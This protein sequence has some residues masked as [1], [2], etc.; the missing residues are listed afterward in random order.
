MN[1][2]WENDA[3]LYR[4]A[5]D[6]RSM[7]N[8]KLYNLNVV[9]SGKRAIRYFDNIYSSLT[10]KVSWQPKYTTIKDFIESHSSC[11]P[12]DELTLIYILY[13]CYSEVYYKYNPIGE[14]ETKESFDS[15]Y[16][17]GKTLLSDFDDIDKNLADS[18]KLFKHI[19][20]FK[21]ID[22]LFDF[23]DEQQKKLLSDFFGNF[24]QT[25]SRR[26]EIRKNFVRIWNCLGE[27]YDSYRER[28]SKMNM[29]YSGMMY[30]TFCED[31]S[32]GRMDFS[33]ERFVFVGFNVL[34]ACEKKIFSLLKENN[35]CF[36][37]WDYDTYYT[38]NE[39][40]EAGTFI[41]ENLSMFPPP[42]SFGRLDF[43]QIQ[44]AKHKISITEIPY[45]SAVAGYVSS[46]LKEVE[47]SAGEGL[48]Q[49]QIAIILADETLLPL[50]V[51]YLPESINGTDLS[52]NITMGYPLAM[53]VFFVQLERFIE[54]NIKD[55]IPLDE[56]INLLIEFVDCQGRKKETKNE[57]KEAAY[58]IILLLK[59]FQKSLSLISQDD[60][61][62]DFAKKILLKLLRGVSI[63]YESDAINGLQIMG[64]LE[65]RNLDFRYILFVGASD[66]NI[67][68]IGNTVS[69]IPNTIRRAFNLTSVEKKVSVFAYYFY[70]L[71]Q[72][73][74]TIDFVYNTGS[75]DS[76][77]NEMS[78]FLQQIKTELGQEISQHV[79]NIPIKIEQPEFYKIPEQ[80]DGIK[81]ALTKKRYL[82]PSYLNVYLDC[83][84]RFYF[85]KVLGI[86][87]REEK[88]DLIALA[89]GSLFHH[90]AQIMEENKK[91]KIQTNYTL[92]VNKALE[93]EDW[94]KDQKEQIAGIHKMMVERY[95]ENLDTFDSRDKEREFLLAEF[96]T[97]KILRLDTEKELK[98]GGKIDRIDKKGNTLVICDYKTG[99]NIGK[100]KNVESL[101]D[102][103]D[104]QRYSYAFQLMLYAWLLW[105]NPNNKA[106]PAFDNIMIEIIYIH[107]IKLG[108]EQSVFA[109][110]YDQS[111]HSEFDKYL[112]ELIRQM[113]QEKTEKDF[114]E[115][116]N[117]KACTYCDFTPICPKYNL[118][119][120]DTI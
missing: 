34:N 5:K 106:L 15:F 109:L 69:F 93:T 118:S 89:F 111:T 31:L 66:N 88:E 12:A 92:C 83:S 1:D 105:D 80:V 100:Y 68:N 56:Q 47:Q 16:F 67:P 52:V 7:G 114:L 95:L 20:D 4:V 32:S 43:S 101:F 85:D 22:S 10:E 40:Q 41:K 90:A 25:Y 46:W 96:E 9:F 11:K 33:G 61:P 115:Q 18:R 3:F 58:R 107:K 2:K 64:V 120:N 110:S 48:Q 82:S 17:W 78:R 72:R 63:P 45:A 99:G 60:I 6:I 39:M 24:S 53:S 57:N 119:K 35:S 104:S 62:H 29:A 44:N 97:E 51:R 94:D 19:E 103:S 116:D 112:K 59:D 50:I 55:G 77:K 30:R 38:E 75:Q 54:Q 26:S 81:D 65:S 98:I 86:K 21:E 108:W 71:L 27:I 36:F 42:E 113:M 79:A 28:L 49:N 8:D 91:N 23:L 117:P 84:L 76:K 74:E 102:S 73:A 13:Q 87:K 37:Y 70:R 14:S